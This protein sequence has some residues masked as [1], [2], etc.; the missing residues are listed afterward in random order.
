MIRKEFLVVLSFLLLFLS[1]I[2]QA[3]AEVQNAGFIPSNIWY[4]R[5]PF[6]EGDK[7]KIYTV[8]FNPDPRELSGTVSFFDKNILLGKKDFKVTGRGVQDISIDWTAT[9][10]T[11]IIFAKIENA[12]FLISEGKYEN[13]YLAQN[14]T[15]E[16]KRDVAKKMPVETEDKEVAGTDKKI[17]N[18]IVE[19]TPG[20]ISKPIIGFVNMLEKFRQNNS[21]FVLNLSFIF[22]NKLIFYGFLILIVFFL[23]RFIWIRIF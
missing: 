8:I 19:K 15:D 6:S 18:L 23:V 20:F 14:Q 5:D 12:K 16:S 21:I 11:H 7:I 2:Y 17:Q 3:N 1:P 22:D 9:A 4:S 10:G 13:V